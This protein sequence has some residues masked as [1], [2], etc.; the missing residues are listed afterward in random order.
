VVLN[1]KRR[2]QPRLGQQGL[3]KQQTEENGCGDAHGA[4]V[5]QKEGKE[6]SEHRK[7]RRT[8]GSGNTYPCLHANIP[9]VSLKNRWASRKGATKLLPFSNPAAYTAA[10]WQQ[11]RRKVPEPP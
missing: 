6:G 5:E 9:V 3:N 8:D 7:R 11:L 2:D 1:R 10:R 4:G